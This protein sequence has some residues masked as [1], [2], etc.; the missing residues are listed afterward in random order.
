LKGEYGVTLA[1]PV[2]RV[3]LIGRNTHFT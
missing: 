1:L 2:S 3:I